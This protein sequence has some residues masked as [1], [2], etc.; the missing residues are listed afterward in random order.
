MSIR[1]KIVLLVITLTLCIIT[2]ISQVTA[3]GSDYIKERLSE[4]YNDLSSDDLAVIRESRNRI[5]DMVDKYEAD[6]E[7]WVQYE[8]IVD[9]LWTKI[10]QGSGDKLKDYPALTKGAVL[11]IVLRLSSISYDSSF[12]ALDEIRNDS[13]LRQAM[14]AIIKL[15]DKSEGMDAITLADVNEFLQ[16]VEDAIDVK[17]DGDLDLNVALTKLISSI[18]KYDQ[19]LQEGDTVTAQILH[20]YNIELED[21]LKTILNVAEADTPNGERV[22]PGYRALKVLATALF[23]VEERKSGGGGV[24]YYP[25]VSTLPI[26]GIQS[27]PLP[28][29]FKETI[30]EQFDEWKQRMLKHEESSSS[31]ASDTKHFVAFMERT[32]RELTTLIIDEVPE[33]KNQK[34]IF[35]L[36]ADSLIE[37]LEKNIELREQ[38][39]DMA[40][41]MSDI[42]QLEVEWVIEVTEDAAQNEVKIPEKAVTYAQEVG[43]TRLTV[44]VSGGLVSIP[45]DQ[46]N[47]DIVIIIEEV[48]DPSNLDL[49]GEIR[50]IREVRAENNEG[51]QLESLNGRF[52]KVGIPVR[53]AN[54]NLPYLTMFRIGEDGEFVNVGGQYNPETGMFEA[55]RDSFSLYAVVENRV[56]FQDI[57]PVR[58]WASDAIHVLAAKG[59]LNG[60]AEGEY[61]PLAT[62]TRAEFTVML[63]KLLNIYDETAVET[64]E[65]VKDGSWYQPY[66]ASAV[67]HGLIYGRDDETFD[68]DGSVSRAEMAVM[69]SRALKQRIS[70]IGD[71]D[72]QAQFSKYTDANHIYSGMQEDL[73]LAIREGIISGVAEDKLQPHA[74]SNRAEAAVIIYRLY[75]MLY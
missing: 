14:D 43:I 75:Q 3:V 71:V 22:D 52:F 12:R 25:P 73:A 36:D 9:D 54:S 8:S 58:H 70:F 69:A 30:N 68:P 33:V 51:D 19:L 48:S 4:I 32:L 7:K 42:S 11:R 74:A 28:Q 53:G 61:D 23:G 1:K 39:L 60:R 62:L 16:D 40:E 20:Y 49:P 6:P 66:I 64:F 57:E 17:L 44:K 13:D 67:K 35:N 56:D 37:G 10:E 45:L 5:Q 63:V 2:G 27:S 15:A 65:D 50:G 26:T 18:G 31:Q 46:V 38:V 34:A 29:D 24:I 55:Y 72:T 59:I 41:D 21:I 47:D